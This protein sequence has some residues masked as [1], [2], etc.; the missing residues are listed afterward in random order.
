MHLTSDS[1]I[2][3]LPYDIQGDRGLTI[4]INNQKSP[5]YTLGGMQFWLMYN[6]DYTINETIKVG[7]IKTSSTTLDLYMETETGN[8]RGIIKLYNV[9][10][11]LEDTNS[12]FYQNGR[13]VTNPIIE[14]LTWTSV[15][16]AFA[17]D[18]NINNQIGQFEIY[19]GFVYNN[20]ALFN[21]SAIIFGSIIDA[22]DWNDI[23]S[24]IVDIPGPD[25]PIIDNSWN[26]WTNYNWR[27]VWLTEDVI[28]FTV[29]GEEIH[30][31]FFGLSKATIN[32]NSVLSLNSDSFRII[33]NATWTLYEGKVV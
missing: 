7:R 8:K 27:Q 26:S 1:G 2:S 21:K 5:E 24:S 18:I 16:I 20:V 32:D 31:S 22:R 23:K 3:V 17:E 12:I 11:G 14:P 4:P 6:K 28:S 15:V 29:S 13:V 25:D 33:S 10:T 19:E 9:E 30:Q